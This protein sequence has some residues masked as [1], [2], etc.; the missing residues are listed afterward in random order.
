MIV[1]TDIAELEGTLSAS[2]VTIG[3][4]DGVHKGHQELIQRVV[5]HGQKHAMLSVVVTF[6]PHPLR[7]LTG[8]KTPPFITLLEQKLDLIS[9][10]GVECC[11]VLPFSRALAELPPEEF[12][13]R[14]L[15]QGLCMRHLYI[16]Y[17]YAFGK[18]RAGNYDLL[19]RMGEDC[20]F[21]VERL[22]PVI[23]GSAVVSSTRIR[24]LVQAGDVWDV[25]PLLG[26]F[27]Q[28][29]G[30]VIHGAGRGSRLLGFP[31]ANLRP[32]DELLPKRGIYAVWAEILGSD[33]AP[34]AAVANV[35]HNPTFGEHP[36][37]V[38]VHIMDLDRDLYGSALRIHFVQRLR[39]EMKFDGPGPLVARIKE[40][41]RLARQILA[42]PGAEL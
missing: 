23:I 35:G 22:D 5:Q 20:G 4:F 8:K 30:E 31:T 38:E 10:L 13:R 32:I 3:N 7:V 1:A 28:F 9:E 18:G 37:S 34:F 29:A 36:L 17:D 11:L 21:G 27:F 26:R 6:E 39:D 42:A 14:Y 19:R 33:E 12:V 25:P 40:D 24:D 41:I 15:V 2:C 16:G